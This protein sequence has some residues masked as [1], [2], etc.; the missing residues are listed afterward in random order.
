MSSAVLRLRKELSR[1]R[2]DPQP[3]LTACPL[4]TNLLVW[5]FC[6]SGDVLKDSPY[7]GG[8]YMGVIQFPPEYPFKP[9]SLRMVTPN[10]RFETNTRLCLSMSDFHPES[11]N[12]LWSVGTILNGLVS[13][14]LE[15]TPTAGS[16]STTPRR[17]A[18]L[19]RASLDFNLNNC[20]FRT[21][22]ARCLRSSA[23]TS[24]SDS[25]C[26]LTSWNSSS[27]RF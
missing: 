2:R 11:W 1:M 23:R 17:R 16:M 4:E 3:G 22:S 13:F 19:A 12:P 27:R 7:E 15:E 20:V 6:I 18:E 25:L 21:R 14:M 10:G 24:P 9:P 5:Y 26:L 8:V